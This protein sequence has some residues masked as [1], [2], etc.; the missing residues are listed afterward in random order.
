M[1]KLNILGLPKDILRFP[2][3]HWEKFCL[4]KPNA[5]LKKKNIDYII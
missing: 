4:Y 5:D 3:K 2:F 1:Y